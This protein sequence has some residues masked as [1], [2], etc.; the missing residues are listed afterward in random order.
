MS[1]ICSWRTSA[2]AGPWG[3]V[4]GEI[5]F[6]PSGEPV[7]QEDLEPLRRFSEPFVGGVVHSGWV[8]QA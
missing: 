5:V 7:A 2:P 8:M 1:W 4:A 3:L 6:W